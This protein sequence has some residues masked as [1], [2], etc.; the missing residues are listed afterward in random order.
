MDQWTDQ[1]PSSNQGLIDERGLVGEQQ[2]VRVFLPP[3]QWQ[4]HGRRLTASLSGGCSARSSSPARP[5]SAITRSETARR[6]RR[7]GLRGSARRAGRRDELLAGANLLHG[8][9]TLKKQL[10]E[11]P[12]TRL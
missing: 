9:R 4:A 8:R 3:G 10:V 5:L 12:D 2:R 6:C 11:Q 1:E 7:R